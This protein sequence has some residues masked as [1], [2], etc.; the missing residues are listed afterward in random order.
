[1]G[2]TGPS[3]SNFVQSK[4]N[5]VWSKKFPS[6]VR[7]MKFAP[8]DKTFKS[9]KVLDLDKSKYCAVI[10]NREP[11]AT[12]KFNAKIYASG[13]D[14]EIIDQV[15]FCP[16]LLGNN[17]PETLDAYISGSGTFASSAKYLGKWW[18]VLGV[19][20]VNSGIKIGPGHQKLMD[21]ILILHE[22]AVD[23]TSHDILMND[24]LKLSIEVF[25]NGLVNHPKIKFEE[26]KVDNNGKRIYPW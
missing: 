19:L 12:F 20:K 3:Q 26:F 24:A 18:C 22:Y 10:E 6:T 8:Y 23:T 14:Y 15:S 4:L 16:D 1:M 7:W 21:N 9:P 25:S 2:N 5:R 17:D 13:I 11:I